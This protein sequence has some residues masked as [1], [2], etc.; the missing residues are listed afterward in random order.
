[1]TMGSGSLSAVHVLSRNKNQMRTYLVN[2]IVGKGAKV[3]NELI[4]RLYCF[5]VVY[6]LEGIY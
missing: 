5:C 3:L 4:C 6:F 2:K 1:M